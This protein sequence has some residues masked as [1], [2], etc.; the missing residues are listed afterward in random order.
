MQKCR[1][2]GN[3]RELENAVERSLLL[4]KESVV[5]ADEL[6]EYLGE[7]GDLGVESKFEPTLTLDEVKRIH[8]AKV[9]REN[10]G[11]KMRTARTLKINVKTLYNLIRKLDI[12]DVV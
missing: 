3:V 11:N 2:T 1:W 5:T 6:D 4:S 10:G 8:I 9:L 12:H 7:S